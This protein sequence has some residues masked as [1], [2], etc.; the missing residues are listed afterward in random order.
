MDGANPRG[1]NS[2]IA[3]HGRLLAAEKLGLDEVPVIRIEDLTDAHAAVQ[4]SFSGVRPSATKL[5]PSPPI[6]T[7]GIR[8]R[9]RDG[10][11]YVGA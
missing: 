8:I 6:H 10:L 1:G 11:P 3:G 9:F 5:P 4:V 2:V 7:V